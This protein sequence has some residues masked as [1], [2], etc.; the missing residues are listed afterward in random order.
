MGLD[1]Y[2]FARK[3]GEEDINIA[4]WRKHANLEGWMADRY[5]Q[6]GGTGS[7]NCKEL[8]LFENDLDDLSNEYDKLERSSGFFWGESHP[9]DDETTQKFIADAQAYM[10]DGYKIVYTS[11]W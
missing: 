10:D 2:A 1:Q 7:F 4:Y 6:R 11:W 8:R 9:E 5:A 3:E